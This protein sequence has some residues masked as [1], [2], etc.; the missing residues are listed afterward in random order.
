M[1]KKRKEDSDNIKYVLQKIDE[2]KVQQNIL[3][4]LSEI[5]P[6]FVGKTIIFK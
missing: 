3:K 6:L 5:G 1:N 4:Y 2:Y